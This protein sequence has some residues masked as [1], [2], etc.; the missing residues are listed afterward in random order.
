MTERPQAGEDLSL[1]NL[2]PSVEEGIAPPPDTA[3]VPLLPAPARVRV[4][5]PRFAITPAKLWDAFLH[6]SRLAVAIGLICAGIGAVLAWVT[7]QP[8]YTA[9]AWMQM[10]SSEQRLLPSAFANYAGPREDEFRM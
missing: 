8:K 5:Q 4:G 3:L 9:E 7:Y 6:R 1:V 2:P 10:S